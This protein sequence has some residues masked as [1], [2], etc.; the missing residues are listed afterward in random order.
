P[1]SR[2]RLSFRSARNVLARGDEAHHHLAVT[3]R[4]RRARREPSPD[5]E[6]VRPLAGCYRAGTAAARE[7]SMLRASVNIQ[8]FVAKTFQCGITPRG[9]LRAR[10]CSGPAASRYE[11]SPRA[12]RLPNGPDSFTA[13][14]GRQ[15]RQVAIHSQP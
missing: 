3:W 10:P 9:K 14:L 11:L 7:A 5:S 15:L 8:G 4:L 1:C 13:P 6:A 12:A 2:V